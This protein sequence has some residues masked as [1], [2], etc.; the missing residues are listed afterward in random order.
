MNKTDK[1]KQLKME[2]V[3]I[4][5]KLFIIAGELEKLKQNNGNNIHN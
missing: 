4:A 1:L 2:L 3:Q 5:N